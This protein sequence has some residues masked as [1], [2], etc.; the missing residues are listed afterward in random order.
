[1]QPLDAFSANIRRLRKAQGL[2]QERLAE[3]ADLHLT[4][5]ARIETGKRD[6]GVKIIA[7]IAHGLSVPTSELLVGV[8]YR[9]AGGE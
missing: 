6:P 8:E 7:K 9:P 3:R 1:V 4:D 5:I 2:T